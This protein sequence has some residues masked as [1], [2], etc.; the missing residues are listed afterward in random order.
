MVAKVLT[1][2]TSLTSREPVQV[3]QMTGDPLDP[4]MRKL[5]TF[6]ETRMNA[7]EPMLR[8]MRKGLTYQRRPQWGLESKTA[9][10]FTGP[11]C[12]ILPVHLCLLDYV[13]RLRIENFWG[14]SRRARNDKPPVLTP[15]LL[16]SETHA[17]C[18]WYSS[19]I[20]YPSRHSM[21]G[22]VVVFFSLSHANE[23]PPSQH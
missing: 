3:H 11:L 14:S 15:A 18:D 7:T 22:S 20:I 4:K 8:L 12:T 13:R 16:R 6:G 10:G 2:A 17:V 1:H 23:K 9:R 19:S 21:S 5:W